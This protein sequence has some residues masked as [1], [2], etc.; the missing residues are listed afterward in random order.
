M[1]SPF[2]RIMSSMVMLESEKICA[3]RDKLVIDHHGALNARKAHVM[4]IQN[5][6][7]TH[8]HMIRNQMPALASRAIHQHSSKVVRLFG[9][10]MRRA[11]QTLLAC[12]SHVVAGLLGFALGDGFFVAFYSCR[13]DR[14]AVC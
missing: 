14:V 6:F 5:S 1:N 12:E 2:S 3:E 7:K 4:H 10:A 8:L 11:L 9:D 13:V